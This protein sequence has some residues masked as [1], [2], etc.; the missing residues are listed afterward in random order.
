VRRRGTRRRGTRRV[1]TYKIYGGNYSKDITTQ[2]YL[3]VPMKPLNKVV[4]SI[5]GFGTMSVSSYAKMMEDYER[6]G[7]D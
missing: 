5:P 4:T 7:F 3:G 6:N 1:N 2:T